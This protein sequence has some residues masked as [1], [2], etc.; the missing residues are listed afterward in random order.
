MR[1]MTWSCGSKSPIGLWSMPGVVVRRVVAEL[2]VLH[3][4]VGDVEAEAV[5]AASSQKRSAS[6]IA[7]LTSGLRQ[8]RSGCCGQERVQVVLAGR[9]VEGPGRAAEDR[10]PVVRRRAVRLR[11]APDIPVALRVVAAGARLDEPGVLVGGVVGTKSM[12]TRRPRRVRLRDQRVEVGQRAEERVD[13][14]V[15]G[16]VVAEVGHRRRVEGRDP[17]GVDA[18]PAQVVEPLDDAAQVADA[19]AVAVLEAAR[20]DLIDDAALPPGKRVSVRSERFRSMRNPCR[21]TA[22]AR[23]LCNSTAFGQAGS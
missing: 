18:E 9:L 3:D 14:A 15:V 20:V 10:Q 1:S 13:V 8:L 4:V 17:D 19:V 6:N 7:A 12:M 16:D 22:S 11:V 23:Y 21:G 5:D 2:R